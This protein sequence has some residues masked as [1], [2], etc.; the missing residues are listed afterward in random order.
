MNGGW[1]KKEK[2]GYQAGGGK[3]Q[4]GCK[5]ITRKQI[6]EEVELD[7]ILMGLSDKG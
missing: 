6:D 4:K 3:G 2:E 5:K 7:A 1:V